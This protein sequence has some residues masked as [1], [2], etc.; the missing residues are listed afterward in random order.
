MGLVRLSVG[1][2]LLSLAN[3]AERH[4]DANWSW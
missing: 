1:M 3:G 2:Q 4:E